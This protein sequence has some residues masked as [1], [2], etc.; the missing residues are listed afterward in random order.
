MY[1]LTIITSLAALF[2]WTSVAS[3]EDPDTLKLIPQLLAKS[4][5]CALD[6]TFK[7]TRTKAQWVVTFCID[8]TCDILR[9][10]LR[11]P[12][13][14]VSDFALLWLYYTSSS[15]C[16]ESF[17]TDAQS[18]VESIVERYSKE[19][20]PKTED[21]TASC[22]LTTLATRHSISLAFRRYPEGS[23]FES[24][25]DPTKE[26]SP[27]RIHDAQWWRRNE[28]EKRKEPWELN[29]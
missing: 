10:P 13:N 11:T 25:A 22:I 3:A 18:L 2:L 20:P 9:T 15:I 27:D 17:E 19:C 8:N 24:K 4:N 6:N 1:R 16:L 12:R 7:V 14:I 23:A 28:W 5:K 26:L 21:V 29:R